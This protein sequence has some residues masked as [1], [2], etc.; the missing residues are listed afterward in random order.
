MT[1]NNKVIIISGKRGTGKTTYLLK[2]IENE[3][4]KVLVLDTINHPAYKAFDIISPKLLPAWKQ[5]KKRLLIDSEYLIF[6]DVEQHLTN[7]FLVFE[8][9]TK[10]VNGNL[11]NDIKKIF[12]DS[13]QK[14][15]DCVIMTHSLAMIPP[16][17]LRLA[18][19][20]VLFKT[21]ENI[22]VSKNKIPNYEAVEKAFHAVQN[23]K[24]PYENKAILLQ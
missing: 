1:R 17:V 15:I 23:S 11:N 8:D 19:I 22:I 6:S 2:L 24:N 12:V 7:C 4:K 5:G 20:L 3:K 13:K 21:Q 16:N 14:N 10:Y 18:D 9:A